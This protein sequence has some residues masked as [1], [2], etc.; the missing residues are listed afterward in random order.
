M[1]PTQVLPECAA[2]ARYQSTPP[3]QGHTIPPTIHTITPVA[4][5]VPDNLKG[6]R[7]CMVCSLVKSFEQVRAAFRG[8]LPATRLRG[9]THSFVI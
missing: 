6:L 5:S 2:S 9:V 8:S 1:G 3:S 4:A 7:A